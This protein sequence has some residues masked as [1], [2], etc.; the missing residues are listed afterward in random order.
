MKQAYASHYMG[1]GTPRV[2]RDIVDRYHETNDDATVEESLASFMR[3]RGPYFQA[4]DLPR[5]GP[6][7]TEFARDVGVHQDI[8]RTFD[9]AGFDRLYGFQAETVRRI[10]DDDH[11]LVTAGTGR[12]KTE[13]WLVPIF[14]FICE[15]KAGIAAPLG[16][17]NT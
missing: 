14:Q 17:T 8:V 1:S 9:A 11:T 15:A 2:V 16:S 10:R 3:T 4:L 6:Q 7:W 5:E 12:G 13:S